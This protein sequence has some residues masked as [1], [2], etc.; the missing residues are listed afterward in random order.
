[1]Y[2]VVYDIIAA[3]LIA[4]DVESGVPPSAPETLAPAPLIQSAPASA[5]LPQVEALPQATTPSALGEAA[6]AGRLET[7]RGGSDTITSDTRLGGVVANN[8]AQHVT[9]GANSIASGS[10]SGAVGLPVVIQNSGANVLI[11]NATV[12]NLQFK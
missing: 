3:S 8:S 7:A 1:M 4:V 12:I 11:Q 2:D 9:T 5:P 6:P 10:F